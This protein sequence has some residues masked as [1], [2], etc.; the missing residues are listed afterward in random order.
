MQEGREY[1]PA[2]RYPAAIIAERCRAFLAGRKKD[3][4]EVIAN[5]FGHRISFFQEGD[6]KGEACRKALCAIPDGEEGEVIRQ[7]VPI[8]Q[9]YIRARWGGNR[10][11][12]VWAREAV[13]KE[14]AELTH[15]NDIL[16]YGVHGDRLEL[17]VYPNSTTKILTLPVLLRGGL[18]EIAHRMSTDRTL[19]NIAHITGKSPLVKRFAAFL[20][21]MGFTIERDAQGEVVLDVGGNGKCEMS[22]EEFMKRFH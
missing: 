17:H 19:E 2:E 10:A 20:E 22:R 9:E 7:A 18:Q 11:F 1:S 21:R 16:N 13:T 15:V 14:R 3:M 12:E 6:E 4:G 8:L 5:H